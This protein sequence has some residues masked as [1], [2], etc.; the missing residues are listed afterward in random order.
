MEYFKKPCIANCDKMQILK[1]GV[2]IFEGHPASTVKNVVNI[3]LS[4]I[5]AMSGY[6]W[7]QKE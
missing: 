2:P 5:N 4:R 1:M 7:V 6:I 3:L